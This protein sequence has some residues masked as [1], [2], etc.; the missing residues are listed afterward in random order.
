MAAAPDDPALHRSGAERAVGRWLLRP[1]PGTRDVG[2]PRALRPRPERVGARRCAPGDQAGRR[3][4]SS[5]SSSSRATSAGTPTRPTAGGRCSTSRRGASTPPESSNWP[6]P[7]LR[8]SSSAP[9]GPPRLPGFGGPSASCCIHPR[10]TVRTEGRA[11]CGG[12]RAPGVVPMQTAAVAVHTAAVA[13][14]T[15]A[16]AMQSGRVAAVAVS[17]TPGVTRFGPAG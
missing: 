16:V 9:R 17:R 13:V 3:A 1:E 6:A 8:G 14:Q 11:R 12:W 10:T 7:R 4:R 5:K 2:C 15:A